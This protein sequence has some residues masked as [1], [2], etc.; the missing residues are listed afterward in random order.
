MWRMWR[1]WGYSCRPCPGIAGR[2]GWLLLEFW[3]EAPR[4]CEDILASY[5]WELDD[6]LLSKNVNTEFAG[7]GSRLEG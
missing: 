2:P 6:A 1:E 7:T 5:E 4:A 3:V